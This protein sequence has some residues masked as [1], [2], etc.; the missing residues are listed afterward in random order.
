MGVNFNGIQRLLSKNFFGLILAF[1]LLCFYIFTWGM[2]ISAVSAFPAS[3]PG[4]QFLTAGFFKIASQSAGIASALAIAILGATPPEKAPKFEY[5]GDHGNAQSSKGI[6]TSLYLA[7]WIL[8]G[9][10]AVFHGVISELDISKLDGKKPP[11]AILNAHSNLE[12]YGL[13]WFGMALSA[14]FVYFKLRPSNVAPN[15]NQQGS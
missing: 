6:L 3:S 2:M 14:V 11:E 9:A 10:L 5:L 13:T 12:M 1:L 4:T 7:A 8:I 15:N